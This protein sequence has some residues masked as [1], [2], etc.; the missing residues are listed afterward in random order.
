MAN[1]PRKGFTGFGVGGKLPP[2]P[3]LSDSELKALS[4]DTSE[5]LK[6]IAANTKRTADK[7]DNPHLNQPQIFQIPGGTTGFSRTI[8]LTTLQHN[9]FIF[10]VQ[11]GAI[12]LFVGEYTGAGQADVPN[13]GQWSAGEKQQFLLEEAGRKYVL[14]NPSTTTTAI[15]VL[16]PVNI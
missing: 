13:Y 7:Y 2:P 11:S 10:M 4:G 3:P 15:C 1:P 6:Q 5:L 8:D 16:I 12:N 14:V 9:S